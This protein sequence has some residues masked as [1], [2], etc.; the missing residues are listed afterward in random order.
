MKGKNGHRGM[1]AA[2]NPDHF[3]GIV[4][5]FGA[6]GVTRIFDYADSMFGSQS[7]ELLHP[8]RVAAEVDRQYNLYT[9]IVPRKHPLDFMWVKIDRKGINIGKMNIRA[10]KTGC[11]CGGQKGD[12][13]GDDTIPRLH[14]KRHH[15]QMQSCGAIGADHCISRPAVRGQSLLK[16]S[17]F[18]AGG[19]PIAAQ[20]T[21][22]FGNVLFGNFLS[23]VRQESFV[24]MLLTDTDIDPLAL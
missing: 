8:G 24:H 5:I 14:I 20:D 11:I 23:A 13:A 2:A 21:S 19:Q 6:K 10:D 18:R 17:D 22:H 1:A 15:G 16:T 12:G 7:G 9:A 3:P 4:P